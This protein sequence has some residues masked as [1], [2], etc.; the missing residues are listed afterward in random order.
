MTFL[1]PH[2]TKNILNGITIFLGVMLGAA[3]FSMVALYNMT[4][5]IGHAVANAKTELDAAGAQSIELNHR[6]VMELDGAAV[7]A[8]MTGDGLVAEANPQYVSVQQKWPIASH[9]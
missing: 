4:V 3:V 8:V 6:I 9:Y 1:Q 5:N 7:T 2:K